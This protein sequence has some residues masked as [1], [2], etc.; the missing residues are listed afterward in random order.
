MKNG[1]LLVVCTILLLSAAFLTP[2]QADTPAPMISYT[3]GA[4]NYVET[5]TVAVNGYFH[6]SFCSTAGARI[7]DTLLSS[8]EMDALDSLFSDNHF[9][10]LDSLY[11]DGSVMDAYGYEISYLGKQV[12]VYNYS[13]PALNNIDSELHA[14]VNKYLNLDMNKEGISIR[15]NHLILFCRP[16]PFNPQTTITISDPCMANDRHVKLSIFN[17]HGKLVSHMNVKGPQLKAGLT[18]DASAFP[19]GTYIACVSADGRTYSKVLV[20]LK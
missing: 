9:S 14:L 12:V 4:L 13:L 3:T 20:L 2:V 5:L 18:W 16:N 8:G 6:Y 1:R 11:Y 17:V 15:E 10:E 19:S 7:I